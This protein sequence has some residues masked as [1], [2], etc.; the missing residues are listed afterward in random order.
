MTG[1]AEHRDGKNADPEHLRAQSAASLL[2]VNNGQA[3]QVQEV[4]TR[5]NIASA[6]RIARPEALSRSAGPS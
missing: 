2:A 5:I 4:F 6:R 1:E 3:H